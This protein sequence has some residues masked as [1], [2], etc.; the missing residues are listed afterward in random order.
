MTFMICWFNLG[1]SQVRSA[2][3]WENVCASFTLV[4]GPVLILSLK[5]R[6]KNVFNYFFLV[7]HPLARNFYRVAVDKGLLYVF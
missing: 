2:K 7:A 4:L 1:W 6:E 3:W 5:L